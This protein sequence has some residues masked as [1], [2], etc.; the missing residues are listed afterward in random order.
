MY[1]CYSCYSSLKW[2]IC[3]INLSSSVLFIVLSYVSVAYMETGP[4]LVHPSTE[5][6]SLDLVCAIKGQSLVVT[7]SQQPKFKTKD[8]TTSKHFFP[9]KLDWNSLQRGDS[10]NK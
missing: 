1:T 4:K 8:Q 3:A 9:E 7:S 5:V 2:G 6:R 10:Q